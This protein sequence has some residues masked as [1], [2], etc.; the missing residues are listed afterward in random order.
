MKSFSLIWSPGDPRRSFPDHTFVTD[1][2]LPSLIRIGAGRRPG[3]LEPQLSEFF[4]QDSATIAR[5]SAL[6]FE[7]TE[8]PALYRTLR[9]CFEKIADIRN[10]QIEKIGK[11]SPEESLYSIQEIELYIEVI[12]SFADLFEN[13][14][15]RSDALCEFRDRILSISSSESYL[16]LKKQIAEQ[17]HLVHNIRSITVGINLNSQLMPTEAGIVQV[18]DEQY[19][20]G[21]LLHKLLRL[22]FNEDHYT[23][24]SPLQPITKGMTAAESGAL[25]ATL[26]SSLWKLVSESVSSWK[27]VIRNYVLD[28]VNWLIALLPE[29]DFSIGCVDFLLKLKRLRLPLAVPE[30]SESDCIIG[31]YDPILALSDSAEP[32]HN[33]LTFDSNGRI[34]ILTG[35]NQGGKSIYTEAVGIAFALL[36]LGLPIPANRAQMAPVSGIFTHFAHRQVDRTAHG[37]F[38]AECARIAEISRSLTENSLFLFD[39]ALSSTNGS[40]AVYIAQE[41]LSAYAQIGGKGIFTTHLHQLCDLVEDMNAAEGVRSCL[42][43]LTAQ[44]DPESHQRKYL[45]TK[46]T[47]SG[48]SY[49][50]DIARRFRLTKEDILDGH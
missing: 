44:I 9:Q 29:I 37:R 2:K 21:S 31:L 41:V 28:G 25:L 7:L 38:A 11:A 4:T 22:D 50:M 39:E 12:D 24:I 33:D 5:R 26:N 14:P 36:H 13:Q 15:T 48:Q 10:L 30:F 6:F 18:N 19:K 43:N 42:S 49:A 3:E 45:I 27:P 34:Y 35:P 8:S 17:S 47:V 40:E 32:I 16:H 20:S 1:L 23:C 46:S